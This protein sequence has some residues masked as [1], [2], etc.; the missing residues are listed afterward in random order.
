M[1][2]ISFYFICKALSIT[3][4]ASYIQIDNSWTTS[5]SLYIDPV[6]I[7]LDLL[8]TNFQWTV[9]LSIQTASYILFLSWIYFLPAN[10]QKN[11][12]HTVTLEFMKLN[13]KITTRQ[14]SPAWLF[15]FCRKITH[16]I[17]RKA[18]LISFN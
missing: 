5:I 17:L 2:F 4:L 11:K 12:N 1:L 7:Q 3:R 15:S 10:F 9:T 18:F 16:N 8:P 13:T 14:N 6:M